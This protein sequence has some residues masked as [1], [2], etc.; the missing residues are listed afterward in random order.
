[1]ITDYV[2]L[3]DIYNILSIPKPEYDCCTRLVLDRNFLRISSIT[4]NRICYFADYI[5]N[6]IRHKIVDLLLTQEEI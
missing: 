4:T 6:E 2:K 3:S 5:E 1:M